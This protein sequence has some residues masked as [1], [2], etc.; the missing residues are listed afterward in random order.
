MR[1]YNLATG[2]LLWWAILLV[3]SCLLFP[4]ASYLFTWPLLFSVLAL[5]WLFFTKE[6]AARPWLRAAILSVA[7]VPGIVLLTSALMLLVPWTNRFDAT[8]GLPLIAV[9]VVFVTLLMGLLIP[10]LALLGGEPRMPSTERRL[11]SHAGGWLSIHLERWL[12]PVSAL[13]A[14]IVVLG[15]AIGT[16][17]FDGTHP[18]T[19]RI[20]YQLNA[21]TGQA[22]WLSSD[23]Q[24]DDWT[25]QFFPTSTGQGPFQAQAPAVALATPTVTLLSNTLS[26][27]V[28]TL[29]VQVA[30]P[31]HAEGANVL[32]EAQG[33]IVVA[34]L[35]GK[36][37]DLSVLPESA[38]H[39]LQFTYYALPDKGFELRLLI[40]SAAPLKIT[41][42][43]ISD[44]LP[45]IPGI[46][47][48]P[49]P[50]YLM[51]SPG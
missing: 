10:Q 15:V 4:G 42:Q 37:F 49:R 11:A 39:Q 3:L 40:K 2:T 8:L 36:P 27:D 45:T 34:T 20:T 50:A 21:N 41:V 7:A 17:G 32:V 23:Q 47:I 18:G 48:R 43:D 5:G 19:D 31:R 13:L 29:R 9:P 46:T 24:L 16:S 1:L 28:L 6:P 35:D 38:R 33:E 26:G 14:G 22:V 25:R 30:S 44:G 51:P 12:V